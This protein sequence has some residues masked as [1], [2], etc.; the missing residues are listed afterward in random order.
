MGHIFEET[1]HG[2][3][4]EVLLYGDHDVRRG[5]LLP[6][7][8]ASSPGLAVL[9][10]NRYIVKAGTVYPANDGTA[11]GLIAAD[12]D[13]TKGD[14]NVALITHGVIRS[15]NLP[16]QPSAEAKAALKMIEFVANS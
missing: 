7:A 4:K 13:V 12:T 8:S 14:R 5:I 2:G 11:E 10:G 16:V 6:M 1:K 3:K 15:A 9:E